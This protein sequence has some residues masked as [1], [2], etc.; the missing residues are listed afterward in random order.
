MFFTWLSLLSLTTVWSQR[1]NTYLL[2]S[3]WFYARPVHEVTKMTSQSDRARYLFC[4]GPGAHMR[5]ARPS[6]RDSIIEWFHDVERSR[7]SGLDPQT[8]QVA[9]WFHGELVVSLND[10]RVG[11]RIGASLSVPSTLFVPMILKCPSA[12]HSHL[13]ALLKFHEDVQSIAS[14]P[15]SQKGACHSI[16]ACKD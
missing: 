11:N 13:N 5:S 3:A 4:R 10:Q 9:P 14:R 6:G 16:I 15:L 7:G 1:G 12:C 8:E 2:L